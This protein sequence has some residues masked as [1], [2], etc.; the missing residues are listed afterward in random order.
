MRNGFCVRRPFLRGL[1]CLLVSRGE[2]CLGPITQAG[3]GALCPA[4]GRA[5]YGCY[6]PMEQP[7]IRSLGSVLMDRQKRPARDVKRMLRSFNGYLEPFKQA[8][9]HYERI[10]HERGR[11]T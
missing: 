2:P 4:C 8:S 7:N 5:C 10:E 1:P 6:G 11:G 3:C 9:E